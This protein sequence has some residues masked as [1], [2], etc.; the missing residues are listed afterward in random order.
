MVAGKPLPVTSILDGCNTKYT[1]YASNKEDVVLAKN[2]GFWLGAQS[3]LSWAHRDGSECCVDDDIETDSVVRA[4]LST[5]TG[6]G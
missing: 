2:G 1:R 5:D 3:S 4:S 6:V